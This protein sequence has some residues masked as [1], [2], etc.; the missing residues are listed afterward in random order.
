M[1]DVE[2]SYGF[3][4]KYNSGTICEGGFVTIEGVEDRLEQLVNNLSGRSEEYS[5]GIVYST[6]G[7]VVSICKKYLFIED[8]NFISIQEQKEFGQ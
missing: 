8:N 4:Y 7:K 5:E 2:I 1:E 3:R 6:K